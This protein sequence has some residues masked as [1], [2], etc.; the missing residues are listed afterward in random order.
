MEKVKRIEANNTS[1][2]IV[3]NS[4]IPGNEKNVHF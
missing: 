1:S 3:R 2:L 4:K